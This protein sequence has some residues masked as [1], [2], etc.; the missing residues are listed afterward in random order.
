ML[1]DQQTVIAALNHFNINVSGVLHIGAHGCEELGFYNNMN[2]GP[3]NVVWIEAIQEKVEQATAR[4]I[5]NVFNAVITDKDDDDVAFNIANNGESSSVLDFKTHAIEHPHV[6]FVAKRDLKTVTVDTFFE[7]NNLDARKC[8]FW[9]FDIQGA[10]L[11]A[12]KGAKNAIKYAK[13]I[14]LEVNEKELYKGCAHISEIDAFL[15]ERG[16]ERMLTKM[17]EYG[18]GDALYLRTNT[19]Q[20]KLKICQEGID[21]FGHQLEGMLRVISLSLNNKAEYVY[22][23]RKNFTFQHSNFDIDKLQS[24]LLNA[25]DTLGA[26]SSGEKSYEKNKEYKIIHNE[27]RSFEH[28]INNDKDYENTIYCYDG[29]GFGMSVPN[30]FEE[31]EELEKSLPILRKAFVLEN[32]FLPKPTYDSTRTNL[33]CHIRLGDAEGTRPLDTDAILNFVRQFQNKSE[34]KITIH[35]DGVLDHLISDNT[36]VFGKDT[37]VLQILSDFVHADTMI[38]N[39]SSLS[40]AAHLLADTNQNV[41]CPNVAGPT[42]VRRILKK[43]VKVGN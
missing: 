36:V 29:V 18:W 17:T 20:P 16:F 14:Y 19:P 40:I 30:N 2:I 11:L 5:P 13:A 9:N 27:S 1:I 26:I 34:Y 33:V 21:G 6:V 24:Y 22:D 32:P 31:I 28:I 12:L 37:D 4:G 3:L 7:R 41:Y 15:K 10:E 35:T 39:Y 42:F 43:C 8:E 23:F 25:L 38:I